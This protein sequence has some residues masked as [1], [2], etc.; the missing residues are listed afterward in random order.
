MQDPV[1][2]VSTIGVLLGQLQL[3][4]T[5][6]KDELIECSNERTELDWVSIIYL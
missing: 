5:W 6:M 1:D 2:A 4:V 3:I